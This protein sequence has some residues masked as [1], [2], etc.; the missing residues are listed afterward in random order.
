MDQLVD[1]WIL[2]HNW[3]QVMLDPFTTSESFTTETSQLGGR[4]GTRRFQD[5]TGSISWTMRTNDA[6]LLKYLCLLTL[7]QIFTYESAYSS[8]KNCSVIH[9]SIITLMDVCLFCSHKQ[10][11][12]AD[13]EDKRL[14]VEELLVEEE[15]QKV[16][17]H[18]GFVTHLHHGHTFILQLQQVLH[19]HAHAHAH[20]WG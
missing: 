8:N 12:M 10:T 6:C 14:L 9:R 20:S 11:L 19:S 13:S 17:V 16:H 1:W 7:K 4:K 15:D 18:F 5:Q 2:C 3:A